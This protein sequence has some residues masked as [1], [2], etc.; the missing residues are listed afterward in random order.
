MPEDFI[1][2]GHFIPDP[3][4]PAP[5]QSPLENAPD[6]VP[7]THFVSDEEK[8]GTPGQIAKTA[9]EG[10]ARGLTFGLSDVL[11]E[12]ALKNAPDREMRAKVNPVTAMGSQVAGAALPIVATGGGAAPEEL[13][14]SALAKG[15]AAPAETALSS[16]SRLTLPYLASRAGQAVE[17]ATGDGLVGRALGMGVEGAAYGAG[18]AVSDAS[19]GD[20]HLTAQKVISD[21]GMGA[22]L[23]SG[24]GVLSKGIEATLPAATKKLTSA[25]KNLKESVFGTA[26][27]PSM[28]AKTLSNIG[29]A[30][31]GES[32]TSWSEAFHAGLSDIDKPTTV[33]ALSKNLEEIYAS[34][35]QAANDL[36]ETAAPANI[37]K[38]LEEMP[39]PVA[40]EI[41]SDLLNKMAT[42]I[43]R[44][45][46]TGEMV[47]A[48]SSPSSSEI[49]GQ[50]L[51]KLS[52][53][54]NR[55]DTSFKIH[56][57]LN[58]FSKD[59]DRN[60]LIKFDT[61]PTATQMA[62]QEVLRGVRNLIRGS[63]KDP[64]VWGEAGT[65]Y[66]QTLDEYSNYLS[67][68]KNF[69]QAFMK[70]EPASKA[71]YIDPGKVQTFFNRFEDVSQ[72]VKKQYLDEFLN[73]ATS[74]SK[75]SENYHGYKAAED[76]ISSR[77]EALSKKNQE[78]TDIASVLKSR[79][80]G[81]TSSR[82]GELGLGLGAHA[83]GIPSPAVGAAIGAFE[84]YKSIKNPYELGSTLSN[85]FSKLQVLGD[86][87]EAAQ[88]RMSSLSK[89]VFAA[90][91]GRMIPTSSLAAISDAGYDKKVSRVEALA[92][93]PE[94]LMDHLQKTTGA[95]DQAAPNVSQGI[96]STITTA[97]QF[98][99]SKV[100][101]PN[102]QMVFSP[103]WEPSKTQKENFLHYYDTVDD[104]L[105]VFKEIK[106]GTLTNQSMEV[107]HQVY[108]KLL[109]EMQKTV[110]EN[111]NPKKAQSLG[112]G[113]KIA[114]AKFL[115]EPL[116]E[117]M[118]PQVL[119]SNQMALS[120]NAPGP[121][122]NPPQTKKKSGSLKALDGASRVGSL[123]QEK[124]DNET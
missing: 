97:V 119:A 104:P 1:P 58:N 116:D 29:G 42:V 68:R 71:F 83:V 54:L 48:L 92:H 124:R 50:R 115:G 80:S 13:A 86:L 16:A 91:E 99:N 2:D 123:T 75:A 78:L 23:G 44:P 105:R 6:F 110:L 98:L 70:K 81:Q 51:E 8:Y 103:E 45:N 95:F 67:A 33:R 39:L 87:A 100:P 5:A 3:A 77:V 40:K 117:A 38:S 121:A 109:V 73:R 113:T 79:V 66:Q 57:A 76:S 30:A 15:V 84:A 18:N 32:P 28:V 46:E 10:G 41:G 88:K 69:Q 108:P 112:Y 31:S 61:L 64:E 7:D 27:S 36:Y 102:N 49:V 17:T 52:S 74:L 63:L 93:Q 65:H 4:A 35:K 85:T 21:I 114:L 89:S 59:L 12:A 34:S 122:G 43:E 106:N 94:N 22:A 101:R 56:E 53:E 62:D 37:G 111:L 90:P 96:Q 60:G 9:L 26:E 55:A 11:E 14:A 120:K 47:S 82:L 118:L 24:L 20:P 25:L 72:D 19:L 107:L